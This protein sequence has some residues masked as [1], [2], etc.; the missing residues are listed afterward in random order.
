MYKW[1]TIVKRGIPLLSVFAVVEIFAGQLLQGSQEQLLSTLLIFLVSIPV[2]NAVGGNLGSILGARIASG[3]HVGSIEYKVSDKKMQENLFT[4]FVMGVLT[5]IILAIL[6]YYIAVLWGIHTGISAMTFI[7]IFVSVG[8][9]LILGVSIASVFTAFWS[10]KKGLD[11]D[12]MVAPVVTTL[13][14]TLGIVLLIVMIGV[15]GLW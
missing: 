4:A 8:I 10:F 5:Y 12:D 7:G 15:V 1:Q 14:D 11:P 2:I 6:I 9:L 13:C 3:L